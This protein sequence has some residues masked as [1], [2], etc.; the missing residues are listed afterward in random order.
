MPRLLTGGGRTT[1]NLTDEERV[2]A[3][4]LG[5]E[6]EYT[7]TQIAK[8]LRRSPDTIARFFAGMKSTSGI[9]RQYAEAK[10]LDLV[11]R[12]VKDADVDQALEVLDRTD[13]LPRKRD[14]GGGVGIGITVCVGMPGEPAVQVPTQVVVNR[15]LGP[16][17]IEL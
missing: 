1:G 6:L 17:D 3:L 16:K 12:V 2:H 7:V 13:V 9:A 5:K 10:S 4:H 15:A 14:H 11:R 8:E